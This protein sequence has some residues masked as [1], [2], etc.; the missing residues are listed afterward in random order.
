MGPE[1]NV[2]DCQTLGSLFDSRRLLYGFFLIL[3]GLERG[4]PSLLRTSLIPLGAISHKF[5]IVF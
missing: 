3:L 2:Y 4:S 5:N 1:I